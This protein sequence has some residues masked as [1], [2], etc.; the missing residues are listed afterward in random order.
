MQQGD[1]SG[2]GTLEKEDAAGSGVGCS[3]IR[4]TSVRVLLLDQ[5]NLG[6]SVR[7]GDGLKMKENQACK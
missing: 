5:G 3:G 4:A 2:G 6:H 1:N 7:N